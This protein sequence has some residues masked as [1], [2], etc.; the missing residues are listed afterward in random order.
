MEAMARTITEAYDRKAPTI[1]GNRVDL[2]VLLAHTNAEGLTYDGIDNGGERVAEE[3]SIHTVLRVCS[4]SWLIFTQ[5]LLEIDKLKGVD[6]PVTRISVCGYS[7]GGLIARYLI[8]ILHQRNFFDTVTPVNFYAFASPH[9]GLPRYPTIPSKVA[10]FMGPKF[11]AR[12]GRQFFLQDK[13]GSDGR[14]LLTVMADPG[15]SL[16]P[17]M[18]AMLTPNSTKNVCSIKAS[19]NSPMLRSTQTQSTT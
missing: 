9:C 3:V 7:L 12:T 15:T 19:V 6:K 5:V 8:G 4:C 17:F 10:F 13:W 11:L 2:H 16:S 1:D 18:P 14:P